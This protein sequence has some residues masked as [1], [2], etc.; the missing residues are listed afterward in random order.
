MYGSTRLEVGDDIANNYSEIKSKCEYQKV[1][2]CQ[3]TTK[4]VALNKKEFR[5]IK[6]TEYPQCSQNNKKRRYKLLQKSI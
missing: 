4:I 3:E 5:K 1:V 6:F 2:W